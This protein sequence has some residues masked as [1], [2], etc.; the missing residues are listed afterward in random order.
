MVAN[1]ST[2]SVSPAATW[3]RDTCSMNRYRWTVAVS[4]GPD[5]VVLVACPMVMRVPIV[6][7]SR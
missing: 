3:A 7:V 2:V 1:F 4:A 6:R 5:T